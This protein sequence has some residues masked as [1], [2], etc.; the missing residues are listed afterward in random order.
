MTRSELLKMI[1]EGEGFKTEFKRKF[2]SYEKIA[3]EIIAFAN[4][5]GGFIIF[6]VDDDGK[7]VGVESEKETANLLKQTAKDYCVPPIE[8]DVSVFELNDKDVVVGEIFESR[9]KP[10]RIQDYKSVINYNTA[11]V[12]LRMNSKCV[13]ASKEMIK[14]LHTTYGDFDELKF[15]IGEKEKRLFAYLEKN[16]KI[17]TKEFCKLVNISERRA[18]RILI[19]LV[20]LNVIYLHQEE[21]GKIFF[22]YN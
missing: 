15:Q 13:Q 20:R 5:K 12:Y 6:G 17:S 11:E 7:I 18:Q 14:L 3:K 2:S 1:N 22:S 4:S 10:H 21:N 9:Q 19:K 16:E 8:L